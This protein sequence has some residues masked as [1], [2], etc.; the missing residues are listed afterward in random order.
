MIMIGKV[1][2]KKPSSEKEYSALDCW[3]TMDSKGQHKRCYESDLLDRVLQAKASWNLQIK[4]WA[5]T[6]VEGTLF[7][8][9]LKEYCEDY[10]EWI[11]KATINQASKMVYQKIGFVPTFLEQ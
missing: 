1:T 2:R 11:F 5:E 10:P 6:I 3:F 8:D 4:M 9:E 7:V